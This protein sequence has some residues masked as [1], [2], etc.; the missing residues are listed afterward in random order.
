MQR[1]PAGLRLPVRGAGREAAP[2][3]SRV[4]A[5]DNWPI[6]PLPTPA[7]DNIPGGPKPL[8]PSRDEGPSPRK[9]PPQPRTPV[10][11]GFR[12][13]LRVSA[14]LP[15]VLPWLVIAEEVWNWQQHSATQ[16]HR[17]PFGAEWTLIQ[18]C[19]GGDVFFATWD[20]HAIAPGQCFGAQAIGGAAQ[21]AIDEPIPASQERWT[22]WRPGVVNWAN[23]EAWVRP[24]Q[25]PA[26]DPSPIFIGDWVPQYRIGPSPM[27]DPMSAP[28]MQPQ[29]TPQP[30][31]VRYIPYRVTSP[32]PNGH[33]RY[34]P[35][36]A[37]PVN[38][39]FAWTTVH[40]S[41]NPR[42]WP[43]PGLAYNRRPP[44][45]NVEK[46]KKLDVTIATNLPRINRG[47]GMITE[48]VD[49]IDV[50]WKA[51]DKETRKKAW[52]EAGKPLRMSPQQKLRAL[53]DHWD[54]YSSDFDGFWYRFFLD[55]LKENYEDRVYGILGK[56][57][58]KLARDMGWPN[59]PRIPKLP[60]IPQ[61]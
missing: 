15:R 9:P 48:G 47:I 3:P 1:S 60:R 28:I 7:N 29:A 40:T 57:A 20:T 37:L 12:F 38:A 61:A 30:I 23:K 27:W 21:H 52:L 34:S 35:L 24:V 18:D 45:P 42:A 58:G 6:A 36:A 8:P 5:N 54:D 49:V 41:N 10:P 51:L 59:A 33:T 26:G 56:A 4:P 44:P 19:P 13:P 11:P 17:R 50:G 2:A 53:W 25:D 14:V 55:L 22:T 32:W 16:R 46:E 31:P 43:R 39:T